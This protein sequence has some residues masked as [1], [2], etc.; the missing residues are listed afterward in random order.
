M[1]D[2]SKDWRPGGIVLII[3]MTT[4]VGGVMVWERLCPSQS[5][6]YM[7]KSREI[8]EIIDRFREWEKD[9]KGREDTA[10]RMQAMGG[11]MVYHRTMYNR[12][13]AMMEENGKLMLLM[14]KAMEGVDQDVIGRR[15]MEEIREGLGNMRISH[16]AMK[17]KMEGMPTGKSGK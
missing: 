7:A 5:K 9:E 3:T 12:M 8:Q 16:R 13:E 2:E 4:L 14:Y 17:N 11:M 1:K 6:E 15:E 10:G